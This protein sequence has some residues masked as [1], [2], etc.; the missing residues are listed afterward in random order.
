[1]WK[2]NCILDYGNDQDALHVNQENGTKYPRTL[3]LFKRL[4]IL[5]IQHM[6][7]LQLNGAYKVG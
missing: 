1:M 6:Y 2:N 4:G 5:Y 7:F 3:S